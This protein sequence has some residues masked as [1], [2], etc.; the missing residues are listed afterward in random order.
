MH[1]GRLL[2]FVRSFF[3]L[4]TVRSGKITAVHEDAQFANMYHEQFAG[5]LTCIN[6]T[7]FIKDTSRIKGFFPSFPKNDC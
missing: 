6:M 7:P 4:C 5:S 3:W 1:S 2:L